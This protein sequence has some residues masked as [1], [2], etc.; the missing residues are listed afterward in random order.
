MKYV[1]KG[2]Y[3]APATPQ[4]IIMDRFLSEGSYFKMLSE[5]FIVRKVGPE[6]IQAWLDLSAPLLKLNN[7]LTFSPDL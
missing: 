5:E 3:G 2:S 1:W 4:V 6:A 7:E